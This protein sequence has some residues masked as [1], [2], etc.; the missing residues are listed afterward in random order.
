MI[1]KVMVWA[2]FWEFPSNKSNIHVF[3]VN[4]PIGK[5]DL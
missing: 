5:P 3:A 4:L 2:M 1:G